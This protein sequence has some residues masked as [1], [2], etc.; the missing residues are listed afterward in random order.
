[1]T[2]SIG[3]GVEWVTYINHVVQQK[4]LLNVKFS[5]VEREMKFS[6][7]S[8]NMVISVSQARR[9][10]GKPTSF[11]FGTL[12]FIKRCVMYFSCSWNCLKGEAWLWHRE[13]WP[14]F[15]KS[16]EMG[17]IC[18]YTLWNSCRIVEWCTDIFHKAPVYIKWG[19]P[20]VRTHNVNDI[21]SICIVKSYLTWHDTMW[22]LILIALL[23]Q[24]AWFPVIF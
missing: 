12:A 10:T 5:P 2:N 16:W 21:F 15:V 23:N 4:Y 18:Q 17:E 22:F 3:K 9:W 6:F 1:M 20:C 24:V 14:S 7:H 8:D 19:R 11:A 13:M